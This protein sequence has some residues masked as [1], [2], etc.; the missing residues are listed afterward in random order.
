MP[1]CLRGK[2]TAAKPRSELLFRHAL[3]ATK[4][5]SDTKRLREPS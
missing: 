2:K 1:S 4:T 5:Q 3:R